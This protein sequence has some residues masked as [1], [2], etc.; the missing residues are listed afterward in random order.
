M[1]LRRVLGLEVSVVG[2]HNLAELE[3]AHTDWERRL[4]WVNNR[5][6]GDL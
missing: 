5:N 1:S 6:S 2:T 3:V 4:S